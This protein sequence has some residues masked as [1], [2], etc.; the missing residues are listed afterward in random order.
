M[1]NQAEQL[2]RVATE[3]R[4]CELCALHQSRSRAVPGYGNPD[5]EILFIGEAP[6]FHEDQQGLPF[7]GRSGQYLDSLLSRI[8][9]KRQDVFITNIN[10]CRPPGNRDPRPEEIIACKPYLDRQIAII[11]TLVIATL[12]RYSM[13]LFFPNARISQIHGQAKYE[14]RRAYYPF[15]HPAAA[16]RNPDLQKDME[17]DMRRLLEVITKVQAMRASGAA[18]DAE[19]EEP[20][21][22]LTLF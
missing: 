19:D 5:A 14:G 9:L 12:G 10:K 7:V 22:Q 18:S 13:G 8:G 11:D 20:P 17:G 3:I 2:E 4:A 21:Q 1:S 6:G 16:L 15:Y